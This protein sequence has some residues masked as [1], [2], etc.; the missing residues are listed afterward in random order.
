MNDIHLNV[1]GEREVPL[2]G[3]ETSPRLLQLML[4]DMKNEE[5]KSGVPID[6]ILIP[7]DFC[8]HDMSANTPETELIPSSW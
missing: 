8:A 3:N 4:D 2:V 7:G 5:S 6:A 1:T